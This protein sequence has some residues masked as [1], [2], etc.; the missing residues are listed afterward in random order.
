MTK[1]MTARLIVM[2]YLGRVV[3][4]R[5]CVGRLNQRKKLCLSRSRGSAR[6]ICVGGGSSRDARIRDARIRDARSEMRA[7]LTWT[8]RSPFPWALQRRASG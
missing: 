2:L 1:K 4:K 7:E 6:F 3:G 8:S 5:A